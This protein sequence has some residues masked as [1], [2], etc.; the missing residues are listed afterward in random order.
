LTTTW[1][2]SALGFSGTA[3]GGAGGAVGGNAVGAA[4]AAL[5]A[6]IAWMTEFG[7]FSPARTM[8]ESVSVA[9]SL[10]E[11]WI[12]ATMAS[13]ETPALTSL[14]NVGVCERRLGGGES[15]RDQCNRKGGK[16][17]AH[18]ILL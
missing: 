6:I 4:A 9:K 14:T 11:V 3:S 13:A 1:V 17:N 7:T 2:I 18:S 10:S 5:R 16:H 12:F 8:S 15:G